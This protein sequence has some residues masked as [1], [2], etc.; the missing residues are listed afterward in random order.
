MVHNPDLHSHSNVSDGTLSP[1]AL[2]RCALDNGVDLW[3]LTDHDELAGLDEAQEAAQAL[4]LRFVPGVEVSVSWGDDVTIHVVGLGINPQTDALRNGLAR[5]REGR[6]GRAHRIAQALLD[7]GIPDAYAGALRH[8]SNPALISRSHFARY[9][10]EQGY[11]PDTQAV[12]DRWL[13]KDKPGYVP[14]AWASLDEAVGWIRDAGGVAVMAHPQ[15]YRLGGS[16]V[17]R[18]LLEEFKS[19]G[20]RGIEVVSGGHSKEDIRATAALARRMGFVASRGSD[21][22]G[23]GMSWVRLG[24]APPLPEGLTPVWSLLGQG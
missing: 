19:V 11:A 4:G 14:H 24:G 7:A 8:V 22:H 12:F 6:D 16:G 20:G 21:W 9:L 17:L 15:R 2:A 18:Q 5:I 23:P 3:A 1:S 10:V 13:A